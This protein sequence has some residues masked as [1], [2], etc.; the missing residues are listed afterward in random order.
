M[1]FTVV[2]SPGVGDLA[3]LHIVSHHLKKAGCDV[4]TVSPH[5]FGKWLQGYE[6]GELGSTDAIFLQYGN[7]PESAK[8][9]QK[10][11]VFTFFGSY[12]ENKHGPLKPGFDFIADLN[13]TMVDNIVECMKTLLK[14]QA[15]SDNGFTPPKDLVH[16]RFP[17]R[18]AIH[19]TSGS[20]FRNW[21]KKK[22]E[23]FAKWVADQGLE[24]VFLPQFPTLE[25]L[26]SFIYESG[27]FL[28][29]D[30]GPGHIASC[31]KIPHLI[32][33]REERHMRHWRPGWG[34]GAII[35]PPKWVPNWKGF[36][37]REKYWSSFI[38]TKDVINAFKDIA[39]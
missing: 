25:A 20:P 14:I 12:S 34:H 15:T 4:V 28:G 19:T 9:R 38:S 24:P 10:D 37:L 22:F 32:I 33:G 3:I 5:R 17:K 39:L 21:P 11:N 13:R 7:T 36:R 8:I 35:T 29:N 2:C 30:S 6:F 27:Y 18:V 26:T 31:L 16:R 1:K 23:N